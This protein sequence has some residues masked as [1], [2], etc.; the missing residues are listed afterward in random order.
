MAEYG[1]GV[2]L[3]QAFMYDKERI[4]EALEG[5]L[6]IGEGGD[7]FVYGDAPKEDCCGF[8]LAAFDNAVYHALEA[9]AS[10]SALEAV[11]EKH[12]LS[13]MS[14]ELANEYLVE[15]NRKSY[16]MFKNT[17]YVFE[18]GGDGIECEPEDSEDEDANE[19]GSKDR[20]GTGGEGK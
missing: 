8:I 3:G 11:M 15:I 7:G 16:D 2:S 19:D 4:R 14:G 17:A 10:A 18:C 13:T 6:M 12:G 5:R 1:C 20:N 9:C